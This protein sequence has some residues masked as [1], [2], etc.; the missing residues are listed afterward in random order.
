MLLKKMLVTILS[1]EFNYLCKPKEG[2]E[3]R[4][5]FGL[6][7]TKID[8]SGYDLTNFYKTIEIFFDDHFIKPR[9]DF[10][11]MKVSFFA[12]IERTIKKLSKCLTINE[13]N[14]I[15]NLT[16]WKKFEN[17]DTF[18]V[19]EIECYK[20]MIFLARISNQNYFKDDPSPQKNVNK[21]ELTSKN[22]I[23]IL[24]HV[25]MLY[26]ITFS[27]KKCLGMKYRSE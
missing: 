8:M 14:F 5:N 10:K 25:H 1:Q 24:F 2:A 7:A 12:N 6:Y 11:A 22:V 17:I 9:S 26:L 27:A 18:G 16:F 20:E 15:Q 3:W 19:P 4:Q 13:Y 23:Y 21:K